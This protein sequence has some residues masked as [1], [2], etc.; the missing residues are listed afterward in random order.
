[1]VMFGHV[2]RCVVDESD[3][4]LCRRP[5]SRIIIGCGRSFGLKTLFS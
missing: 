1:M 2:D 4:R 3:Q 5:A